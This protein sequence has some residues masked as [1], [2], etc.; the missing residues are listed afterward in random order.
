MRESAPVVEALGERTVAGEHR[1]GGRGATLSFLAA[2]ALVELLLP[3]AFE[4]RLPRE[5]ARNPAVLRNWQGY[6]A[7]TSAPRG[8]ERRVL[9]LS[10]S[11]GRGPEYPE[12]EIYSSRL[13][14]RLARPGAPP[15]RVVNWSVAPSRVPEAIVLLAHARKLEPEVVLAVFP[16][17]W[18]ADEDHEQGGRP[19]PLTMFESDVSETAWVQPGLPRE[20]R[21]HY[22]TTADAVR[23]L[24]AVAWPTFRFRDLPAYHL[25]V[26]SPRLQPLVP[27]AVSARWY[28]TPQPRRPRTRLAAP[29]TFAALS[30]NEALVRMLN[31]AAAP[32][33][34][35]RVFVLQ[36]LWF[37]VHPKHVPGLETLRAR[38]EAGGWEFLDLTR[39]VPW[40]EFLEGSVH[41]TREGHERLAARLAEHLEAGARP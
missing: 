34:A 21:D 2:V 3:R 33:S 25:A 26:T 28:D 39:A 22:L 18:F 19:T 6:L 37:Q 12:G 41:L 16:P 11:Q 13:A 1:G 35:R 31:Q 8:P 38:L 7:A 9:L 23:S 14:A 20:F 32:L 30:P 10:N 24:L 29:P 15:V 4:A 36:P 17:N 5:T 40:T 27:G